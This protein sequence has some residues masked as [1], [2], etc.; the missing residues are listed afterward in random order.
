MTE[1]IRRYN[2]KADY[3]NNP[4]I[5]QGQAAMAQCVSPL[6]DYSVKLY[7]NAVSKFN[8][9]GRPEHIQDV[10]QF[11]SII[12]PSGSRSRSSSSGGDRSTMHYNV[13]YLPS[14]VLNIGDILEHPVHG[15][16][17]ITKFD[18]YGQYGLTSAQATH[19][20]ST[21]DVKDGDSIRAFPRRTYW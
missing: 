18:G 13:L 11:P 20:G 4:L 21:N 9:K 12:T 7:M 16:M 5:S 8:D 6:L 14:E 3:P 15:K 19:I 17:K 2:K 1:K 10:V